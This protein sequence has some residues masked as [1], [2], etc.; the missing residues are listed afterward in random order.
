MLAHGK[1]GSSL[2]KGEDKSGQLFL[3]NPVG[4]TVFP[5]RVRHLSMSPNA[6]DKS[7]SGVGAWDLA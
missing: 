3:S 4:A 6:S 5:V 2:G 7:G 1:L